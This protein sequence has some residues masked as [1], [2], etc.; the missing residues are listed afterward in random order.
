MEALAL[1]VH[2]LPR[3]RQRLRRGFVVAQIV[4]SS[5]DPKIA[6]ESF[7]WFGNWANC[8]RISAYVKGG[9]SPARRLVLKT[10]G[11]V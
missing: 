7:I 4:E 8:R 2:D 6:T 11:K 1:K 3:G 5:L 9:T 10:R